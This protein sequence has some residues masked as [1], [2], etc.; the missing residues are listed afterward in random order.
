M[1]HAEAEA[2]IAGESDRERVLT[3]KGRE[4]SRKIGKFLRRNELVP[5]VIF[6]S[7]Y[8]RSWQTAE[9]VCDEAGLDDP[10]LADWLAC[11]MTAETAMKELTAFARLPDLM[12]VGHQPDL[13]E[14]C[15]RLLGLRDP[16]QIPLKKAALI[17]LEL[18]DIKPGSARL[19][20]A[21]TVQLIG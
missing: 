8:S 7:P 10:T 6:A 5:D 21:V 1:R 2:R 20:F 14:L 16:T 18:D 9:I 4:Q 12:I 13:G 3:D 15:A 11:G 19:L 17:C